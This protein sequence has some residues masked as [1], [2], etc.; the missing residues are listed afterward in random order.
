MIKI[1]L[2]LLGF[3]VLV[4]FGFALYVIIK[5]Y[6]L[7]TDTFTLFTGGNGSGKSFW[8]VNQAVIELRKARFDVFIKN[9][10]PWRRLVKKKPKIARPVLFSTIPVRISLREYSRPL[11]FN[12]FVLY[13]KIPEKCI[14]FIDEVNLFLSQMDFK[15]ESEE[16]VNEF[17]TL[18]R[19]QTKGGTC[20]GKIICNTQNINKVH[21]CI[22]YS[23]NRSYNLCEFRKPIFG[24][25][26]L[27]WVK[28]RHVSI[29]DDIK[30]V[31]DTD[32]DEGR[33]NLFA[34]FPLFRRYDTHCYSD[35]YNT[36][37]TFDRPPYKCMKRNSLVK[38][39]K[40]KKYD[41]RINEIDDLTGGGVG[42]EH[43]KPT[44]K[45]MWRKAQTNPC[46]GSK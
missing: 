38:I 24:L 2:L 45:K 25:P 37:P 9:I 32:V 35:R 3:G 29:G 18:F 12:P 27:A 5:P 31:E 44:P 34:F 7:V 33:H 36:L 21:W 8:S 6:F 39:D 23:A 15:L 16:Q 10:N 11:D 26:I 40:N 19:H 20:G 1:I 22:R 28:C 4:L 41:K 42:S 13:E 43:V 14:V 30:T 17:F 46:Q